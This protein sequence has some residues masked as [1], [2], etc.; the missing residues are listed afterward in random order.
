M[1]GEE[2]AEKKCRE[3]PSAD[4]GEGAHRLFLLVGCNREANDRFLMKGL[5]AS[6]LGLAF[7]MPG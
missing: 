5:M 6:G 2:G 7:I 1:A 4:T 3:G